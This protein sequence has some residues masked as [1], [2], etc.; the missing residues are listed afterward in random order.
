[1]NVL[2]GPAFLSVAAFRVPARDKNSSSERPLYLRIQSGL[3]AIGQKGM[4][5]V[6][7]VMEVDGVDVDVDGVGVGVGGSVG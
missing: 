1:M 7:R 6:G 2:T 4:P 5:V 3:K